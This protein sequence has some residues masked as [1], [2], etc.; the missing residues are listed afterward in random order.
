MVAAFPGLHLEPYSNALI[1]LKYSD[2][3][4]TANFGG[5]FLADKSRSARGNSDF[6][7]NP[8]GDAITSISNF[9]SKNAEA[10]LRLNTLWTWPFFSRID[11]AI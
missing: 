6:A 5:R 4:A 8:F 2:A 7:F 3:I 9:S 10:L 11:A 1:T